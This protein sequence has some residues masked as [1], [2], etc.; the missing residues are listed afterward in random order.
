M[1][2]KALIYVSLIIHIAALNVV[3]AHN[4]I[5]SEVENPMLKEGK[6]WVY[7]YHHFEENEE[8]PPTETVYPVRYTI[9]G[10]TIIDNKPYYKTVEFKNAYC[11]GL[12]DSFNRSDSNLMCTTV[13]ISA[14]II[15]IGKLDQ[16]VF[17]NEWT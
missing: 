10:D 17:N 3:E 13:T 1:R 16:A 14:Q 12:K 15:N 2:T 6:T 5:A 11:I 4:L 7:D 8:E 9:I